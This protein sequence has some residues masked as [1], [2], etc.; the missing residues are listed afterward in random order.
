MN[1]K[2]NLFNIVIILLISAVY[3][4][5]EGPAGPQGE[6]KVV[7]F[8]GFAPDIN[9][10][11]C[12]NPDY[13][14]VYYLSARRIQWMQSTHYLGGTYATRN[15]APCS[16]CHTTEGLIERANAKFPPQVPP[17]GWSVVTD[18]P[19]ST[20]VGC[21]ACHSPHSKGNFGLRTVAPVV[22]W[23]PM[24]E[25]S[26]QTIDLGK[27]N[28]CLNCHQ[29]RSTS[30]TPKMRK[31]ISA[32]DSLVITSSR[33]YPHYGVQGLM[34]LGAGKGGGFEFPGK[35]YGNSSHPSHTQIVQGGCP[36]CHMADPADGLSGGHSN[37]IHYETSSGAERYN[38][39][40]CL[41]SGC[42][43]GSIDV[44]KFVGGSASLTGGMGVNE[45]VHAYLDTLATLLKA[46]K[47]LSS[48]GLVNGN[49]GTSSASSS[50]P[51]TFVGPSGL[52][53][54]GALYNYYFI[55]HD[56]SGGIHN[57]RYTLQLLND[58]IEEMRKP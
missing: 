5:C 4:G 41:Q 8:E 13:D 45:Y 16:G 15:N 46:K 22:I 54:A 23:S 42:H 37:K 38:T 6:T 52:L 34:F 58:S 30:F 9:C 29:T 24:E 47:I 57:S 1:I 40:G 48:S 20:P 36:T 55:E 10:G 18:Q 3:I 43:S 53:K 7:Q 56:A 21:F 11:D 39:N 50:N 28:M 19:N 32:T 25:I 26:D 49:N 12:H 51:R 27:G 14:S 33:W 44:E 2:R 35:T 17:T 31:S